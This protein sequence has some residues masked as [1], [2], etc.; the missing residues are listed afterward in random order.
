MENILTKTQTGFIANDSETCFNILCRIYENI[1]LE[2]NTSFI[3]PNL[4]EINKYTRKE[5]IK[6]L[7]QI[8]DNI[9]KLS[10]CTVC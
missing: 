4:S 10:I 8:L 7:T 9:F 5:Q 6:K 1:I 3:S 2:N